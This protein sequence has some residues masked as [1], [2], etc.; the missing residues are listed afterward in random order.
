MSY[1][2]DILKHLKEKRQRALDGLYN[3]IPLPFPRFRNLFPGI[4]MGRYIIVTANQKV[5]EN[6]FLVPLYNWKFC[7][8][9][10]V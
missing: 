6:N 2:E 10:A 3:C 5:K 7:F 9:F 8:I 1:F 4:Q